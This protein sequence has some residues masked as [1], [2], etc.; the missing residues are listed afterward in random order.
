MAL[1]WGANRLVPYFDYDQKK[2]T[3]PPQWFLGQ[4]CWRYFHL[5]ADYVRRVQFMNG[6]GTHVAPIL[7]YYPLETAFAD[8]KTLFLETRHRD[9]LWAS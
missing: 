2:V 5:Y 9:L 7:I 8:S 4:P 3:W 1:L 6:Q